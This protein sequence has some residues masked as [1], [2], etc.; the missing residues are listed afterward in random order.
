M[1][2]NKTPR[3]KTA[4]ARAARKSGPFSGRPN[5][6]NHPARPFPCFCGPHDVRTGR[7]PPTST[8]STTPPRTDPDGNDA[9]SAPLSPVSRFRRP[10]HPGKA[11]PPIP[12]TP[13]NYKKPLENSTNPPNAEHPDPFSISRALNG[14]R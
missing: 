5:R 7:Q 3:E 14:V 8:S 12:S 10:P 9:L 2:H 13:G 11:D 1:T 6:R 4:T